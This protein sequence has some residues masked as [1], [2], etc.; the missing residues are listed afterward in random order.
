MGDNDHR[1]NHGENENRNQESRESTFGFPIIDTN[2][3]VG[4]VMNNIP[5]SILHQFHGIPT[6]NVD[7]FLFEFNILCRSC[8]Y[9]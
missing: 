4:I 2:N 9:H 3:T 8:T 1:S 5:P 6:T 7:S